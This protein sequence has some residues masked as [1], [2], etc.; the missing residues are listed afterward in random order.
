MYLISGEKPYKCEKC[1]RRFARASDLRVHMPVHS[2]D[3]PYK[4]EQCDKM[5]TRLS[6]LKEH[7]RIHTGIAGTLLLLVNSLVVLA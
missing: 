1:D 7:S 4:C 3:K 6:T 5:F 2:E